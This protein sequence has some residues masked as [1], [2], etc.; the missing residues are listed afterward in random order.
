MKAASLKEI[1]TELHTLH[2]AKV[3]ELC[4]HLAKYKKENKELLT[5][6]LFEAENEELYVKEIKEQIDEQFKSL[7][8]SSVFLAK[9]TIRKVLR[10]TNKY[11]RYSGSKQTEVELLICF[12][13]KIKKTGIPLRANSVLGNLYIRQVQRIKKALSTLHE[14]LQFDYEDDMKLLS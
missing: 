12:C 11:I 13:K 10:T 5:Y 3:L 9:K 8:K 6:L 2:P 1:K 7:N 14:D 4:M